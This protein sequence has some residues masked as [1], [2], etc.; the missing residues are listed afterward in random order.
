MKP[1]R[2]VSSFLLLLLLYSKL[3]KLWN[4]NRFLTEKDTLSV[5][6]HSLCQKNLQNQQWKSS[7]SIYVKK[8]YIKVHFITRKS[9]TGNI[10]E[11]SG[12]QLYT[13]QINLIKCITRSYIKYL[14]HNSDSLKYPSS[15]YA[16]YE[17]K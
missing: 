4:R 5:N 8:R 15:I 11:L 3:Y 2:K 12:V 7:K 6:K 14:C 13:A 16:Q 17:R 1:K 9:L 10:F